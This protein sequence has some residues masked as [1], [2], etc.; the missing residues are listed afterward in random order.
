MRDV[1]LS[2]TVDT[3]A[4][5]NQNAPSD[6]DI[7]AC[8]AS[9]TTIEIR[10]EKNAVVEYAIEKT[11]FGGTSFTALHLLVTYCHISQGKFTCLHYFLL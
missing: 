3:A 5:A 7:M 1:Q 8:A 10:D 2:R 11:S 9:V 4:S 6:S